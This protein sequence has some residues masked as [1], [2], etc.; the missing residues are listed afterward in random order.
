M[1][2]NIFRTEKFKNA[3]ILLI[4]SFSV[5]AVFSVSSFLYDINPWSDA[6]I[7][8]TM[9]RGILHGKKIYVDLF[10]HKGP[11]LYLLYS[12]A[13]LISSDSFFGVYVIEEISFF[14]FLLYTQ[15]LVNLYSEGHHYILLFLLSVLICTCRAF[16]FGGGTAEEYILSVFTI[17]LYDALKT[18]HQD[19]DFSVRS[20][21][22]YGIM[23][24]AVFFIKFN[25]CGFFAGLGIAL[26]FYQNH[27]D[28]RKTWK[29]LIIVISVF[30][31]CSLIL[32]VCLYAGGILDAFFQTYCE[33][34]LSSY[35]VSQNPLITLLDAFSGVLLWYFRE[36]ILVLPFVFLGGLLY[37]AGK[38]SNYEKL[39]V[40]LTLVFWYGLDMIGGQTIRYYIFPVL[41]YSFTWI[42]WISK[43]RKSRILTVLCT[44]VTVAAVFQAQNLGRIGKKDTVQNEVVSVMKRYSSQPSLLVY[45]GYDEGFYLK[46]GYTP[47]CRYFT[48]INAPIQDFDEVSLQCIAENRYDFLISMSNDPSDPPILEVPGY[49]LLETF[50]SKYPYNGQYR[51]YYLYK[52][53]ALKADSEG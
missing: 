14:L 41:M 8:F 34:N 18:I 46:A 39:T 50:Q 26:V 1:L 19:E 20:C 12:F 51:I 11:L 38:Y 43:Q 22:L 27:K 40:I 4:I 3:L 23:M 28:P 6:N 24:W 31:I 48:N 5:L 47:S 37:L 9:G 52:S 2:K 44:A 7:F 30:L 13:A 33:F 49:S 45:H 29:C 42:V 17:C 25:L 21:I 53:D 16:D 15:K 36:N 10:D 32:A 35:E